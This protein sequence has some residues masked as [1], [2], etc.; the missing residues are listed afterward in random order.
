M[1]SLIARLE[2]AEAGSRELDCEV[3]CAVM[4][5]ASMTDTS[6]S[7]AVLTDGRKVFAAQFTTSMD[8]A[9]AL[10]E[11]LGLNW[12][13]IAREALLIADAYPT[14]R[15]PGALAKFACIAILRAPQTNGGRDGE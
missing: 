15:G 8:A 12:M 10:A 2:E 3:Y 5:E 4:P 9:L 6:W 7:G 14:Q 13:V 11:R 1:D